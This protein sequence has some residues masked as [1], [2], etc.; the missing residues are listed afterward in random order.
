MAEKAIG[1]LSPAATGITGLDELLLGGL[2][3][4]RSYLIQGR[5][6]TGKTTLALQFLLTG[7]QAGEAGLYFTLAESK[8][9]LQQNA[10]SHGWSLDAVHIHEL[11]PLTLAQFTARQTVFPIPELEL[12]EFMAE[13]GQVLD[14]V[15]PVRVVF[16]SLT[17]LRLLAATPLR[18]RQQLLMLRQRLLAQGCTVLFLSND[19]QE[20]VDLTLDSLVHGVIMLHRLTPDYGPVRRHLEIAKLRGLAYHDGA[21]DFCIRQGGLV[22]FPRL[23]LSPLP[24]ESQWRTL[25]SGVTALDTL[26]GGGLET[27][28]ACL[29]TG[30]AGT[31]KSTLA[32]LYVQTALQ[33]G[34][35]A[36]VFLFDERPTTWFKRATNLHWDMQGAVD[37]GLLEIRSLNTGELS[38]GEFA[39]LLRQQVETRRVQVVVIDSLTGYL[40]AMAGEKLLI[41]QLHEL[42]AYLAQHGV[43]TLLVVTQ[44]GPLPHSPPTV[45][46]VS[47]LADTVLLLRH[48]EA[49]GAV[50]QAVSVLKKRYA[51]HE[52]TIRELTLAPGSVQVSLP[53]TEFQG[54]LSGTPQYVGDEQ[55]LLRLRQLPGSPYPAREGE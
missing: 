3:R 43:L 34:E 45:L 38:P 36:A 46:D 44:H 24:S 54:V 32:T 8:V 5:F 35:P 7:A 14:E 17:E 31:G 27:G 37:A 42:L 30:Q 33:R 52:R 11:I 10:N 15:Q 28:T 51:T 55:A 41:N 48:F 23:R 39:Y 47:Y 4:A 1:K 20:D 18:Y 49:E 13:I 40:N 22:V 19:L 12:A 16:D 26:L 50:H 9:E 6:G 2:P 21:H 25:A 29:L 53:L